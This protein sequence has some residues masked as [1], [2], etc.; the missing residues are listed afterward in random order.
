M[1]VLKLFSLHLASKAKT[2][3]TFFIEIIGLMAFVSLCLAIF[4]F[5]FGIWTG[6]I[7]ELF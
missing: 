5:F 4:V 3:T 7:S 1:G 2:A 6:F